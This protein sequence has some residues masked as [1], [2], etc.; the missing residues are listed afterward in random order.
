MGPR[1]EI[2]PL[3]GVFVYENSHIDLDDG[4]HSEMDHLL[5]I[6]NDDL[7]PTA[8][9]FFELYI[10]HY[11]DAFRPNN[12]GWEPF[13]VEGS[14]GAWDFQLESG[15]V[16]LGPALDAWE[17]APQVYERVVRRLVDG[18]SVWVYQRPVRAAAPLPGQNEV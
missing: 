4:S 9:Y 12:I 5:Q 13:S 8:S 10:V 15:R 16:R 6:H 11:S 17:E 3:T 7:D 2:N 14:A 18:R 1:D